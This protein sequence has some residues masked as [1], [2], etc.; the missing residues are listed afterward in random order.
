V[1]GTAA[2]KTGDKIQYIIVATNTGNLLLTNVTVSD[3]NAVITSCDKPNP[4]AQLAIGES[5]TCQA[6]HTVT[7]ADVAAGEVMNTAVA[8]A[9]E[10]VIATSGTGSGFSTGENGDVMSNMVVTKLK[11]TSASGTNNTSTSPK[12]PKTKKLAFTGGEGPI[13]HDA[14]DLLLTLVL[15]TLIGL[16]VRRRITN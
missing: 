12:K 11:A 3:D 14:N 7:K 13:G 9:A 15:L 5:I 16:A 2:Q 4:V 10:N 6:Y 8:T 1:T